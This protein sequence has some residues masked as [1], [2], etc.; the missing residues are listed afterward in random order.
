[1]HPGGPGPGRSCQPAASARDDW[2]Q[3][4]TLGPKRLDSCPQALGFAGNKEDRWKS[5]PGGESIPHQHEDEDAGGFQRHELQ[6]FK[7]P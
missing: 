6:P 2:G 7:I 1:M 5:T 4:T 3:S